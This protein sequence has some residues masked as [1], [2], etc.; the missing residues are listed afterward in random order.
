MNITHLRDELGEL[1]SSGAELRARLA[2]ERKAAAEKLALLDEAGSGSAMH[3]R[4]SPPR[5]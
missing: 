5:P 2:D 3:S 4:R 1:K